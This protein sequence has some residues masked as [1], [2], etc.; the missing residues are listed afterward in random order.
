VNEDTV[1][2]PELDAAPWQCRCG[3]KAHLMGCTELAYAGQ[4]EESYQTGCP[5]GLLS[6]LQLSRLRQLV[7]LQFEYRH[8]H[9][10]SV[11]RRLW[12]P[13]YH[14]FGGRHRRVYKAHHALF[15]RWQVF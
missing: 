5:Y 2:L 10:S 14:E 3:V 13:A 4:A 7:T 1:V 12:Q 6:I 11:Q 15:H 8:C 9:N